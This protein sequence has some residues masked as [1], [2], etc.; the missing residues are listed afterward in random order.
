MRFVAGDLVGGVQSLAKRAAGRG[1]CHFAVQT[2]GIVMC[3][4]M[5]AFGGMICKIPSM[6]LQIEPGNVFLGGL[7]WA[8]RQHAVPSA[9]RRRAASTGQSG[10]APAR[11]RSP[12]GGV[13]ARLLYQSRE[14]MG[15]TIPTN[16]GFGVPS[17]PSGGGRIL[18]QKV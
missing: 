12:S 16:P 13:P 17:G 15:R 7:G 1:C 14:L 8:G 10:G 9:P 4:C 2:L 5:Y 6:Y 11:G 3:D 18:G